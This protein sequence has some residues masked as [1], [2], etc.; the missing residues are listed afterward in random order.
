MTAHRLIFAR[1]AR[2]AANVAKALDSKPPGM[3][4]D[5]VGHAQAAALARR[6]TAEPVTAVYA[7]RALRAQQTAA[8]VAAAHGLPVVALEGVHEVSCGDLEGNTDAV[9]RARFAEVYQGWL[10]GDLDARLPGGD[11]A[12]DLRARF[13]PAVESVLAGGTLVI[14]S[15]GAAIPLAVGAMLGEH[16]MT[17]R[18][19]NTGVVI[20]AGV[21]GDWA[22]EHWDAAE[23]DDGDI[24]VDM[25]GNAAKP[26]P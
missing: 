10:R 15:H 7:S 17:R 3:P 21:P 25:I 1:H 6:L 18:V 20:V 19:A 24:T 14:V 9:S 5:D 8:P 4:L 16:T 11:S 26:R 23:P 12:L 22:L 2:T 13:L